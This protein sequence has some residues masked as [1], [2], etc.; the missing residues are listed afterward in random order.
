MTDV[1]TKWLH[2]PGHAGSMTKP[3]IELAISTK[4]LLIDW[5]EM[6]WNVDELEKYGKGYTHFTGENGKA[7]RKDKRNR[8]V[9]HDV[10]I[11]IRSDVK[12][13]HMEEFWVDA[14]IRSNLKYMPERHGKA[15]VVEYEGETIVLVAWHPQ[16]NPYRRIKLVLP[17]YRRSVRRV[18][19]VQTRLEKDYGPSLVL[20]GGDLQLG[21]GKRWA[22]PNQ[23][24]KR[25]GMKWRRHKIDW[26]MWKGD[27]K[28]VSFNKIV[29]SK[30][31]RGMDHLWTTLTL[32]KTK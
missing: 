26:Q 20:N 28:F 10:I 2:A 21:I 22:Y 27:W 14:A 9:N 16:P 3:V 7:G 25:L 4:A 32:S 24:A 15:V 12:I 8:T 6:Y 13:I 17:H 23:M 5:S 29:P 18:Q 19:R 31:N 1:S 30:A 11:S